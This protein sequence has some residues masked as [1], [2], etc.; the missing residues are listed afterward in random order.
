MVY[1][2]Y[3]SIISATMDTKEN[4]KRKLEVNDPGTASVSE[5]ES[6]SA[7]APKRQ[8]SQPG[9]SGGQPRPLNASM[10]K[11]KPAH[12]LTWHTP[13]WP[14][15]I[16]QYSTTGSHLLNYPPSAY[17]IASTTTHTAKQHQQKPPSSKTTAVKIQ[18]QKPLSEQ[19]T[20]Q[21]M[22]LAE[23]ARETLS[24]VPG[25]LLTRPDARPDGFRYAQQPL[26]L[27]DK[28]PNLPKTKIRVIDSD[29]IDAALQM[30]L[31]ALA[32]DPPICIL[33]MANAKR[34]GGG[35]RTGSLAQEEE[36]CYRTSLARTLKYG[37]YPIPEDN[38]IYSP[39]VLVIRSSFANG[40]LLFDC[41]D[42]RQLPVISVI[43]AAAIHKPA[44]KK[45]PGTAPITASLDYAREKDRELMKEKMRV[46]LRTAIRNNH[47]KLV[48]GAFGCGVFENPANRVCEMWEA[49]FKED[50]F[51]RGWWEDV[52][53]AVLSRGR[54]PN[55][56]IFTKFLD[57][58]EV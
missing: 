22:G 38:V 30:S 55:L 26:N 6:V 2:N 11:E 46:I 9:A 53:F 13:A 52:V 50:E 36:L 16:R 28:C 54:D 25:L 24:V 33:N 20:H 56:N 51:S 18:Q 48:L 45:V 42:P 12:S 27:V 5:S 17:G 49:V 7:P 43:S 34:A 57:G 10:E 41:R 23:C 35:F 31:N 32:N 3:H 19:Q 37:L 21:K 39:T 44:T 1:N 40:H 14:T 29:T 15:P 47:R 8:C 58:V 4:N